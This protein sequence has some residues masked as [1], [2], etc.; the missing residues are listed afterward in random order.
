MRVDDIAIHPKAQDLVLGTHGRSIIVLDDIGMFDRGAPVAA[1]SDAVL[2]PIRPAVERF[3]TRMLPTPGARTFQAANPPSGAIIT[4]ALGAPA[5]ATDTAA[6]LTIADASGKVVRTQSVAGGAGLHRTGWDLHYDRAPGV[7]DAD[8]GWFGLPTGAWVLP[9]RYTVTLTARGKSVSQPV[10]VTGD[11]RLD[12]ASGALDARHAAAQQLASL[13]RSF[14]DGVVLHRRMA[15]EYARLD[16]ALVGNPAR[17]DSLA[18]LSRSVKMRLDSLGRRFGSGFSGPKFGFLDLDGSIQASSTGPTVAQ[19]RTIAQLR[20][21]LREDLTSLN[22]LLAGD[23]ADLQ[24]RA[25]A[26]A[27]AL[28]PVKLP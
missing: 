5:S 22:A 18:A 8:E 12:I 13:Q 15:S 2:Y 27:S 3:I 26:T 25:F 4:Y 16:T 28:A 24:R 23:F 9:G 14:N 10:E 21:K 20:A 7:T 1:A 6:R 17:R 11:S 19:Q